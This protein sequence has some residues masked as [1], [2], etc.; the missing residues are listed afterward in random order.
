MMLWLTRNWTVKLISLVLAVGLWYYAVGEESVEVKRAIPLEV[1]IQN[2]KM[3]IL[4]TSVR[5]VWVTLAAPRGLLSQL[6]S[7]EITAAHEIGT[8]VKTAGDYSFRLE[9]REIKLPGPQIR[10]VKIV[11][12]VI[13]VKIDEMIVKKLKIIPNFVGEPAFGYHVKEDEIK[14]DPNAV[15]VEGPKRQLETLD[16][17]K[18]ARIELVGRMRSFRRTFGLDLIPNIKTMSE[19]MVDVYIPISEEFAEKRFEKVPLKLLGASDETMKI[20]P[21]IREISFVLKGASRQ[22]EQLTPE[23]ITA[24]LDVT[25]LT[26]G[27]HKV[28]VTVILPEEVSLKEHISVFV[29]V[30]RP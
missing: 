19:S 21:E 15:L 23:T 17:V 24:Y 7:K 26:E 3:S 20:Q 14:L 16:S 18:T 30:I 28:P 29:S 8:E 5:N 27:R 12:E 1:T 25:G 9:P 22:L 10:V 2:D 13:R 11:P 6:A 4:D